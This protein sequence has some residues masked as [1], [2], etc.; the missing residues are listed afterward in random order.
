MSY[1]FMKSGNDRNSDGRLPRDMRVTLSAGLVVFLG[2]AIDS[3]VLYKDHSKRKLITEKDVVL[4]L[5]REIFVFGNRCDVEAQVEDT[6]KELLEMSDTSESD[7]DFDE[8]STSESDMSAEAVDSDDVFA[9]STCNCQFCIEMNEVEEKW[10][11]WVPQSP[12]EKTLY[13]AIE[14][15]ADRSL[16]EELHH[17]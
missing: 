7:M 1:D 14:I 9:Y 10:K 13:R 2:N 12:L 15:T 3:A 16:R 8:M 11:S 4:A 6:K 17:Q 5:K